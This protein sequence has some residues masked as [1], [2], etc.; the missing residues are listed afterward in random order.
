MALLFLFISGVCDLYFKLPFVAQFFMTVKN[1]SGSKEEEG[2]KRKKEFVT[3]KYEEG[4]TVQEDP[5]ITKLFAVT[6]KSIQLSQNT[7]KT[8]SKDKTTLPL[9]LH[10][11][12]QNFFKFVDD[13]FCFVTVFYIYIQ[14]FFLVLWVRFSGNL[15]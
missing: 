6:R 10:Y 7:F 14:D 9:D 1:M 11:E 12:A 15:K 4:A 3:L 13:F 8:W 2:K 5:E